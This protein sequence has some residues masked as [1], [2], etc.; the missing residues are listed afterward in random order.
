MPTRW[1]LTFINAVI[2]AGSLAIIWVLWPEAMKSH[3]YGYAAYEQGLASRVF[4]AVLLT[5]IPVLLYAVAVHVALSHFL[6]APGEVKA[7]RA[8]KLVESIP[9]QTRAAP[10]QSGEESA[11]DGVPVRVKMD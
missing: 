7:Y 2:V 5:G 9:E 3:G 4:L 11:Q 10:A 8:R 1:K 6:F